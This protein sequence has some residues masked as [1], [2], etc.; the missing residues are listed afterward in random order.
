MS[1]QAIAFIDCAY[2]DAGKGT[3]IDA[4][5]RY[6]NAHLVFRTSGGPNAAHFTVTDDGRTHGYAQYGSAT[7]IDGVQTLLT[8]FVCMSPTHLIHETNKL[9]ALGVNR[10]LDRLMIDK[11][12]PVITLYHRVTNWLR[13]IARNES[14]HGT[15]GMGLGELMQDILNRESDT[16][17]AGDLLNARATAIK[18]RRIRTRKREELAEL[19][20]DLRNENSELLTLI[21]R[22]LDEDSAMSNFLDN[23]RFVAQHTRLVDERQIDDLLKRDGTILFEGSQGV[24]LDEDYGFHPHTTWSKTSGQN[25]ETFLNEHQYQGACEYIGVLRSYSTRHG[26]GPFVPNEPSLKPAFPEMHNTEICMQ[27]AFRVGWFDVVASCYAIKCAKRLNGLAITHM[28]RL[29]QFERVNLCTAYRYKGPRANIDHWFE[30]RASSDGIIITNI[31]PTTQPGDLEYQSRITE[32]LNDCLPIYEE[33][34]TSNF[35]PRIEQ[36]LSLPVVMTSH[37]P[38]ASG[39]IFYP[40]SPSVVQA[41]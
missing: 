19:L 7:F 39:K 23:G 25:V 16:I 21:R 28:D 4:V 34:E 11:R 33:I 22:T 1:S 32:C 14:A 12:C 31:R 29:A 30:T 26:A 13:E 17:Y 24:L 27:G 9:I 38:T 5:A 20:H 3:S 36:E 37:S 2:G 35:L 8:R 10:P 40:S 15:A 41:A 18:L 6:T